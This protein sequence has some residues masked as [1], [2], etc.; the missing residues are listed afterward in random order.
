MIRGGIFVRKKL[1][2]K[3]IST[4]EEERWRNSHRR[5]SFCATSVNSWTIIAS[6]LSPLCPALRHEIADRAKRRWKQIFYEMMLVSVSRQLSSIIVTLVDE[7][8]SRVIRHFSRQF[9]RRWLSQESYFS[10]IIYVREANIEILR[11]ERERE[12]EAQISFVHSCVVLRSH[13]SSSL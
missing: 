10:G 4:E 13:Q 8:R 5:I 11:Q 3:L 9:M 7:C 2:K 6:Q 12:R 1:E